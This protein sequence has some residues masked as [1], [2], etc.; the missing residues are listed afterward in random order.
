MA[1]IWARGAESDALLAEAIAN[2][3]Y[4]TPES[5]FAGGGRGKPPPNEMTVDRH[6]EAALEQDTWQLEVVADPKNDVQ[7]ERPLSKER[8]TALDWAAL[9]ALGEKHAVRYLKVATCLNAGNIN[10]MGLWEGVPLREVIWL[11]RPWPTCAASGTTAT[12]A[13][14]RSR[15][16]VFKVRCQSTGCSKTRPA[17]SP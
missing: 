11:T 4:L 12:T 10:G 17:N 7:I 2:L 9:I 3:E 5:R 6:R 13:T 1:P 16:P 15:G 14:R 8:G